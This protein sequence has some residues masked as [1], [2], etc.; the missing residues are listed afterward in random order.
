VAIELATAGTHATDGQP[1]SG[2]TASALAAAIG[3][4]VSLSSHR[5]HQLTDDDLVAD[6]VVAM[7][8]AQV[9]AVRRTHP[10]AA[11]RLATLALL[12][13]E[14]PCDPRSLSARVAS[15]SLAAREPDDRDD[16]A[17]PAGGGDEQYAATMASLTGLCGELAPRI[18][19]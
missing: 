19:S 16:V 2:R 13:R 18:T 7:E 14:L 10:G 12:A 17:D 3:R 15:M 8:A 9:R 1:V 6:V 4:E 11:D 5:A